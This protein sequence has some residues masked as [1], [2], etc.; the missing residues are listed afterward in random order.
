MIAEHWIDVTNLPA[1]GRE[2]FFEDNAFWQRI[3]AEFD[4][5][6]QISGP[7]AAKVVIS[8]QSDGLLIRGILQGI[9]LATCHRCA[10]Q[11]RLRLQQDFDTFEA[12]E[13]IG[14]LDGE[15]VFLRC[16]D[17]GWSLNIGALLREEI[18]LALPE[19]ILCVET[20]LGLC[21]Q[22]GKNM[23]QES[24]QCRDLINQHPLAKALQGIR[25]KNN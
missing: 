17:T 25:I 10:E 14:A 5:D 21:P 24:C 12:F 7:F 19:K 6:L 23:N 11:A 2:F 3:W 18:L 1:H 13:D 9:I 16:T 8:A 22:C 4:Q 15:E 20:C